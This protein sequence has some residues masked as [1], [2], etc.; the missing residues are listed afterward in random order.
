MSNHGQ[1]ACGKD[2]PETFR[3]AVFFE[4]ACRIIVLS[5]GNCTTI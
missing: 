3:R 5:R 1:V 4:M 2:F